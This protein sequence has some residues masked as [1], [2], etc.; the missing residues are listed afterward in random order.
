M[1]YTDS[2]TLLSRMSKSQNKWHSKTLKNKAKKILNQAHITKHFV[3]AFDSS[4]AHGIFHKI[5]S[6][7][8]E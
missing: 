7:F 6:K 4:T 3:S 2:I 8:L 5:V 1:N